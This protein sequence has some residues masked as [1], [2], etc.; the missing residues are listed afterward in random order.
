MVQ[1]SATTVTQYLAKLPPERRRVISAVRRVIRA[2]LPA[3]YREAMNW[4]MIAYE[5]PLRRYPDT[6]NGQPLMYAAL[7]AQKNN[8]AVYL[9]GLR[10]DPAQL[11]RL[12]EGYRRAGKKP[13]LGG[14]CVR[15]RQ[16]EELDLEVIGGI[17]A[18]TPIEVFLRRYESVK[19]R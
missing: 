6:Y 4:G 7:A 16:L 18:S 19:R 3:G 1:S 17:I 9:T 12:K 14:S 13:D 11:A 2:N 5:I 15:F 8:Y 10:Q